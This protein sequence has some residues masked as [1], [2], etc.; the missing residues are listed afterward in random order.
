MSDDP[1]DR[2]RKFLADKLSEEDIT[3][4]LSFLTSPGELDGSMD[5]PAPFVGMPQP[6]GSKYA[7]DQRRRQ[8]AD[9]KSGQTAR[10]EKKFFERFPGAARIGRAW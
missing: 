4:A 8:L 10:N 5:E 6:G 1:A 2:L 3:K 9:F 7:Q